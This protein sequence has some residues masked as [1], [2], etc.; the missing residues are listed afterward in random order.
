MTV[1][2]SFHT[3]DT[4][5]HGAYGMDPSR[6]ILFWNRSAERILGHRP[7]EVVGRQCYEVLLGLPEQPS[8]LAC[9]PECLTV[10]LAEERRTA[11]VARLRMRCESG[12]QK[13]VG[14]TV[15]HIPQP[16]SPPALLHV[17]HELST[18]TWPGRTESSVD[19]GRA[20]P[21]SEAFP[22]LYGRLTPR[23]LEVVSCWLPGQGPR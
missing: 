18:E 15:L 7:E 21:G 6:R 11:P 12:V 17:F 8:A 10:R 20:M 5:S 22:G 9:G 4:A 1:A 23:E 13:R 14:V 2:D 3:L 16:E 19:A